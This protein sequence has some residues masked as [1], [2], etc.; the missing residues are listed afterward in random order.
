MPGPRRL[1]QG[2]DSRGSAVALTSIAAIIYFAAAVSGQQ[3]PNFSGHWVVVSPPESSGQKQVVEHTA[4]SLTVGQAS[5]DG[6]H[7]AIYNLDG[8]ESRNVTTSHGIEIVN[9][10]AGLVGR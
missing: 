6:G 8:K 2:R 10:F 4:A 5:E 1:A 3:M 7:R 9:D